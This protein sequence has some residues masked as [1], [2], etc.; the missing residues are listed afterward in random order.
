MS[1]RVLTNA[2]WMEKGAQEERAKI[3]EQLHQLLSD[4][5]KDVAGDM[6]RARGIEMAISLI[7]GDP[8]RDLQR[9]AEETGEYETFDNPLIDKAR[10]QKNIESINKLLGIIGK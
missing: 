1:E 7:K 5:V 10:Q 8:L 2:Y 3:L 4:E 9:L 6:D